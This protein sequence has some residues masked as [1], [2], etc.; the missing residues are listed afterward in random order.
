[1]KTRLIFTL[2]TAIMLTSC[3]TTGYIAP[4]T[5]KAPTGQVPDVSK[6][7][8][9]YER[10]VFTYYSIAVEQ[11]NRYGIPAS[12]TLAQGLLESGAGKSELARKSNNHFGIKADKSWN[13]STVSSMDNGRLCKFRKYKEVRESYEDHSRFL[14]ERERYAS[15]F[16]LDRTDYIGWAKG[17]KKAGYAEDSQYPQKLISLIERY[18]LNKYDNYKYSNPADK[19][20]GNI[21]NKKPGKEQGHVMYINGV[22]YIVAGNDEHMTDVAHRTGV[23]VK[24]LRKYNDINDKREP[25][26]GEHLFTKKK[27]SKAAK[28]TKFHTTKQ[29]ESLYSIAQEYGIKLMDLFKLNPEYESYTKLKVGDVIRLR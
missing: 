28:G 2:T 20:K 22:P 19:N 29:G 1:M 23:S 12:I 25:E 15:L 14:V 5:P 27:K 17:L 26:A 24:K 8:D 9:D 16:K 13:G 6:A 18:G 4:T 11:M 7:R 3:I 10:Y 21:A